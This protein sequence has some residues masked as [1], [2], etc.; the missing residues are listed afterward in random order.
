LEIVRRPWATV[1]LSVALT[2]PPAPARGLVL[3]NE[4]GGVRVTVFDKEPL[5][6]EL[7]TA[8]TM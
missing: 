5:A 3:V 7:I 8:T 2:A 4:A 6:D 1:S